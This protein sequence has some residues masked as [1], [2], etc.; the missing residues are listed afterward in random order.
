MSLMS[1]MRQGGRGYWLSA[2]ALAL[3]IGLLV[4]P[5]GLTLLLSFN[6]F[7][8]QVGVKSDSYTLA[9]YTAVVSDSY[10]YEIFLRTFWISALVTLLCVLIGV[11]EAYILSRMGTPWRSIFLILILTPLLISVVVRAF[12]WSLLLGADGLINQAIQLMGGRPVKLLYTPFAVIIALVHV[13]LP[14]MIIPVWT[15]LQKLD[16]TAEQ[17]ALSLG[18]SQAK[19]MRLIVLPQVMPGVL[20]GS[21]IVFGLAASSFAIPGLLGGR[22]LKMVATVIYDQYLSEL[23][24]P[25]GAT[26]AVALLLVNLLVML[27]WNRMIEGRY[28][29]TLGE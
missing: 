22:R 21:L 20:S 2:P 28:K 23:N 11:P 7:D 16:P 27:S 6:V 24:W 13:M 10:F 17:A 14:F 8:Y 12:G 26:L 15:S 29:K 9:N 25:M 19:V 3:Y 18:A 1:E 5:L 4:L